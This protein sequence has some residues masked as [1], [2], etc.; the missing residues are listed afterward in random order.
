[1]KI[2]FKRRGRVFFVVFI[3]LVVCFCFVFFYNL[4]PANS[5][6][7]KVQF[8][9]SPG[10]SLSLIAKRLEEQNLIRNQYFFQLLA[11]GLK[12]NKNIQ[13]GM[14]LLSP[15]MSAKEIALS[16]TKGKLDRWLTTIEG[17]R[18]E[19]VAQAVGEQL[20]LDGEIFFQ[21]A[22]DKEGFLFPDSYLVP[23]Y[24]TEE[25]VLD[26]MLTNFDKKTADLWAVAE[27]KGLKKDEVVILASLVEREAKFSSDRPLVAGV[28]INRW[29]AGWPLQV[30]ATV[31]YA[32]ANQLKSQDPNLDNWWP[33]I[34]SQD[35]QLIDS[36][37]NT[38]RY[39]GLPPTAICNPSS[40]SLKAVVDF[41]PT[42]FWFYLSDKEGK[43]HF[44]E[45]LESHQKN[46]DQF[47]KN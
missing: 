1:M 13:A 22:K 32:K 45:D 7:E 28:L 16:L 26:L 11:Y 10:E 38:Y 31:Q 39:K 9:I 41:T 8:V 35:L 43:I 25:E 46:I 47:L 2:R 23:P 12:L 37:Y 4:T 30:D 24:F 40:A 3:L 36:K 6:E 14:F 42:N 44:A 20:G 33:Q 18:S 5:K 17:W 27:K 19:Q 34:N 21:L 15:S 29:R